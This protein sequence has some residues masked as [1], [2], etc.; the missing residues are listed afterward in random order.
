MHNQENNDDNCYEDGDSITPSPNNS[1]NRNGNLE[2]NNN[3]NLY[4]HSNIP[5]NGER[6][7][8]VSLV[9]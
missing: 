1:T 5:N 7:L 9:D 4:I 2:H 6:I 3:N 8:L